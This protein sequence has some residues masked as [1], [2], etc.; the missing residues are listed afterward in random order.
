MASRRRI[1]QHDAHIWAYT[2]F[3]RFQLEQDLRLW[4]RQN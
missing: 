3:W 2:L 4:L 1:P